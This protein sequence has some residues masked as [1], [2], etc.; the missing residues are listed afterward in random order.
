MILCPACGAS[1]PAGSRFCPACGTPVAG[2]QPEERRIVTVLF[3]DLVGFT[4]LSEHLDPEQVKRIIDSCF[5]QLV[6]VVVQFGGRVDKLLGDGML[7][8]FGA[9]IAH[10]DDPERAVRAALRMQEVLAAR[11]TSLPG[12]TRVQMRVGINTGEVLVGT[13]AGTDYTAMGDVVNT[14][15]RLQVAAPPGGVL[16]GSATYSL[17]S[18]TFD[19]AH[20][21]ELQ[22]KGREQ[23]VE[24]WLAITPT[25]PPGVRH[26]RRDVPLIGRDTELALAEAAMAMMTDTHRAVVLHV[27]GDN[28][29]GKSRLVDE[30]VSRLTGRRDIAVLEGACVPYGESNVWFPVATALADHL[31]LDPTA[32]AHEVRAL[33]DERAQLLLPTA[34]V[35]D[36][37]RLV[38]VFMHVLGYPSPIDR[39]DAA[40]ARSVVHD[41]VSTVL[42]LRS[43]HGPI[44]LCIDDLHWADQDLVELLRHLVDSLARHDIA[45]VTTTRPGAEVEWP[46]SSERAHVVSLALQPLTRAGTETLARALLDEPDEQ[47]VAALHDRS[48]GNPLFLIELAAFAGA[49]PSTDPTAPRELPDSLRTLIAARL[50]QLTIEQRQ[51][52][53]NAAVLGTSGRLSALEQFGTRLGQAFE[54]DTVAALDDLGLLDVEGSRW[55]FC[56]DSVRDA[57][58]QQLTKQARA[59]RHAAVAAPLSDIAS[60]ADDRAH[61]LATAAELVD[62]IGPVP[63]VPPTISVT[64]VTALAAAAERALDGGSLRMASR[65]ATRALDLLAHSADESRPMPSSTGRLTAQLLV[66]RA[67]AAINRRDAV[68][69]AADLDRV[70]RLADRGDDVVLSAEVHRLRGMLA[71]NAGRA[72]EARLEL[73]IAIDLLRATT[74]SDLLAGA[75]RLRGFIE[76][77]GGSL[78]DAEWFFGEADGLYQSIDDERGMAY[79][80]QHRAWISFLSGD[81]ASARERLHRAATA[82]GQMGDRNGVGWAFGLLAFVEFHERHFDRAE[83][84]AEAVSREAELRGDR[85]AVGMMDTLL[86]QMKLWRGDVAE[87]LRLAERAR[88]QFK[89]I[90]D[91]Y[92]LAQALA[93]LVRAQIALGRNAAVQR[94]TEELT[95]I[96]TS[97]RVGPMPMLALAGAAMHRG[98]APA[99]LQAADHAIDAMHAIGARLP[100]AYVVKALALAQHGDVEQALTV[101]DLFDHLDSGSRPFAEAA[102]ALIRACSGDH[103]RARELADTIA[104]SDV[105]TYLDDVLAGIA[106]ASSSHALGLQDAAVSAAETAVMRATSA[107]DIVATALTTAVYRLVTGSTHPAHDESYALSDGWSTVLTQLRGL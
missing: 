84:L 63:E 77:F 104:R 21:G 59:V 7:V 90:D 42:E 75:L 23:A 74:R 10:E 29:L 22:A 82:L 81:M 8:L 55:E 5:E 69:A 94:S 37:A 72:N 92:G 85:W 31:D 43:A 45:L 4:T 101:I 105:S 3:A 17:T 40:T 95:A 12:D 87:G 96:A 91:Q 6:E 1:T 53:E 60:A 46:P 93:P 35:A 16:V 54:R 62:E 97:N 88:A 25:A 52:I 89:R 44:V 64:A 57:A 27:V 73:G 68:S 18:H 66:T 98:N 9:P 2:A 28:G 19:Y 65:H 14:A 20:A 30:V 76:M 70:Q 102:E 51:V 41:A 56:S 99:A 50:D 47:F 67:S 103:V 100:E 32:P 58:Y 39:L 79:V 106:C 11:S 15:S 36:R 61:H 38:D 48:G 13:L 80:E 33:A 34:P 26:R 78:A 86:A 83:S 24:A 49:N 71:N 107:G